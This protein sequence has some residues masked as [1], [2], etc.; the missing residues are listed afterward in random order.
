MWMG[1][2]V[3]VDDVFLGYLDSSAF[4][5]TRERGRARGEGGGLYGLGIQSVFWEGCAMGTL[6]VVFDCWIDASYGCGFRVGE[7]DGGFGCI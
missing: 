1:G 6:G 7:R 2:W 5:H 3:D 4:C